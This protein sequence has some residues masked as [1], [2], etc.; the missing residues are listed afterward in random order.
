MFGDRSTGPAYLVNVL[1]VC[2]CSVALGERETEHQHANR[3][4]S[5]SQLA[6]VS[7]GWIGGGL[8]VGVGS[9][10]SKALQDELVIKTNKTVSASAAD[11]RMH[12]QQV[13]SVGLG[14]GLLC[15]AHMWLCYV[16]VCLCAQQRIVTCLLSAPIVDMTT[17]T[18]TTTTTVWGLYKYRVCVRECSQSSTAQ[19]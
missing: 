5:R 7:G 10:R 18:S 17:S 8:K 19:I 13:I 1:C 12:K 9:A 11:H 3:N 2:V 14:G 6:Q 15:A 4:H 16:C